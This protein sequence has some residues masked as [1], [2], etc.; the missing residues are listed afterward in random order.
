[1]SRDKEAQLRQ[2][3]RMCVKECKK[4][5]VKAIMRTSRTKKAEALFVLMPEIIGLD[6]E[7]RGKKTLDETL[8]LVAHADLMRSKLKNF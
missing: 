7:I 2:D 3:Y 5:A 8:N 6:D 4:L 1:M